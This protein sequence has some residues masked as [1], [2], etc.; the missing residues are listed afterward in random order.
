MTDLKQQEDL[1]ESAIREN[2]REKAFQILL[3]LIPFYAQKKNFKKAE[4]YRDKLYDIDPLAL[5]IIVRANEIIEEEKVAGINQKHRE[6][7]SGLYNVLS[8]DQGNALFYTLEEQTVPQG[9]YIYRQGEVSKEL[10]FA[11]TGKLRVE[12]FQGTRNVFIK[13]LLPGAVFGY[14][15]FFS[16]SLCTTSVATVSNVNL[17]KLDKEA[18]GRLKAEHPGLEGTLKRYCAELGTLAEYLLQND[19]ERREKSRRPI[20]G[21]A[22][23]YLIS[24]SGTVLGKPLRV[25]LNDISPNGTSFLLRMTNEEK[26][27]MLLGQNIMME[28]SSEAIS[29]PLDVRK[30]GTIV[31]VSSNPFDDYSFHIKFDRELDPSILETI[32]TVFVK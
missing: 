13:F 30:S 1:L 18:F 8:T 10:F 16:S 21:K 7:F 9:H 6:Q 4:E 29:P 12:C 32:L 25:E 31:G 22:A 26:A 19:M 5:S 11:N 2:D 28:Y 3:E 27:D 15:T 17:H 24:G 23:M 14:D 20:F